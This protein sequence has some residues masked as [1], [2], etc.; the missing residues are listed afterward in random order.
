MATTGP[1]PTRRGEPSRTPITVRGQLVTVSDGA[2]TASYT[3]G[4][5]GE[6]LQLWKSVEAW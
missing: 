4:G 2:G 3:Y 5:T 1:S 6:E